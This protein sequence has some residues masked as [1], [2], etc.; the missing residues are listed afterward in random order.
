MH[1]LKDPTSD[2]RIHHN[3]D[4][5]GDVIINT[6]DGATF[7]L[8]AYALICGDMHDAHGALPI[9]SPPVPDENHWRWLCRATA[10]AVAEYITGK[11][12]ESIE[13]IAMP[14]VREPG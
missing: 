7:T 2:L 3:D 14:W 1:T 10:L 4:W 8:P 12:R 6:P 13:I 5:S 9:K 11:V